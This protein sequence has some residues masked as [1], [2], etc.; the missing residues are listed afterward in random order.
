MSIP[1]SILTH[2]RS[3]NFYFIAV[4]KDRPKYIASQE[5]LILDLL[6]AKHIPRSL[7]LGKGWT[8]PAC[9]ERGKERANAEEARLSKMMLCKGGTRQ[10]EEQTQLSHKV[11]HSLPA[12]IQEGQSGNK[13]YRS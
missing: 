10:Q 4:C 11:T 12:S 5:F 9:R 2:S 8:T 7:L 13:H 6:G 3:L 1:T